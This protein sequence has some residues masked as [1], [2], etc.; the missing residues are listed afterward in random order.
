MGPRRIRVVLENGG[1]QIFNPLKNYNPELFK[2]DL[3]AGIAVAALS[4]PI[5]V[6][7][8]EIAGMPPESGL[9]TAIF[10]LVAYFI[11]GSSK[12]VII[13]TDFATVTLF[14]ATVVASFG[15]DR[16]SSVQF[17]MWITVTA[18]ILMFAAGLL[19]LG[20]IAN[21]LSKPVLIG[22]L[23]GVSIMLIDSQLDKL[24][25]LSMEQT[26]LLPRIYE[27]FQKGGLIHWPTFLLGVGSILFLS[28]FKKISVRVPSPL[29]LIVVTM[30]AAKLFDFGALGIAFM[31]EI[32]HP[33]PQFIFPDLKLFA[34]HFSEI[35]LASAA[36]M[37]VA[38]TSEIPVVRAFSK[39]N[40]GFD[41]NKEFY[42]LG[43]AHLLIGFF[44]GY[45]VSGDDSRTAVN[46]AVGGKT[47]LVNLIAAVL[48]FLLVLL[49]P[50]VLTALPLVTIAAIIAAAGISMFERGAGL[51][52]FRT[53]R[54]EFLVF[55][56]CVVG[57]LSLGVYQGILFAIVLA[58][59]QIIK[60]SSKPHQTE[61]VY[62]PKTSLLTEYA[63][64]CPTRPD[65]EILIYRFDS[66]LFF[67]NAEYF[68]ENIYQRAAS[69][70]DLRLIVID[71]RP[72]NMIDL[73]ALSILIEMI[74]RFNE[75]GVT[76]AFAGANGSFRSSVAHE[77]ETLG[78]NTDVFHPCILSTLTL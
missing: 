18:G 37:F 60:K 26:R 30:I 38:Y 27:V 53:N 71:A 59:L 46:I 49:M 21:F 24:T 70:I 20:F 39:D 78:L 61:L 55:A 50:G 31:P 36:V 10:A 33:Y 3:F 52:L 34:D 57:V 76:V 14:A 54:S 56:V 4:V 11:L 13:G 15:S 6:A 23:N 17:M 28:L 63:P 77:L 69:K 67:F 58:L 9:Y 73:S 8:A 75:R 19:N 35:F 72:I 66:A 1:T 29:V 25:G 45:P 65:D 16:G 47:K 44:G 22:Y 43:L 48:I 7:Y 51:H 68:V 41:P 12:Q 40:V 74:G 2:G 32:Q 42:A 64:D 5:A 62:D